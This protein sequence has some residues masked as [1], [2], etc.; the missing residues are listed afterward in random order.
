MTL[1]RIC[2]SLKSNLLRTC[3]LNSTMQENKN[4][5]YS[6]IK[7]SEYNSTHGSMI[8]SCREEYM[9]VHFSNNEAIFVI[10]LITRVI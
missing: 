7:A 4:E 8:I 1:L 5:S 6:L 3:A 10:A 2:F 9:Y